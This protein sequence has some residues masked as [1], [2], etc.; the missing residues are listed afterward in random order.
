MSEKQPLQFI[1]AEIQRDILEEPHFFREWCKINAWI[2]LKFV[3]RD[4]WR[5]KCSKATILKRNGDSKKSILYLPKDL[6]IWETIEII[7]A[8]DQ[9]SYADKSE[10]QPG[11]ADEIR[12]LGVNFQQAGIYIA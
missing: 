12:Q 10:L 7:K 4:E 9:D 3:D 2:E 11:R 5:K 1:E 8:I 6:K